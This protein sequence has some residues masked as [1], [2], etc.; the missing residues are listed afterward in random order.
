MASGVQRLSFGY[1][2]RNASNIAIASR[3][4]SRASRSFRLICGSYLALIDLALFRYSRFRISRAVERNSVTSPAKRWTSFSISSS[5]RGS[6]GPGA[7]AAGG[8]GGGG[9]R[10]AAG[11]GGGAAAPAP[12]AAAPPAPAMA[13]VHN[14]TARAG[15]NL[16]NPERVPDPS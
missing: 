14:R 4:R 13:S 10:A 3:R 7:A 2:S 1:L 12:G 9:A 8:G 5:S 6:G 11:G 15:R 16:G